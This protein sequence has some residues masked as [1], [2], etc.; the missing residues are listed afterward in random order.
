MNEPGADPDR[1]LEERLGLTSQDLAEKAGRMI[2][3]TF[4]PEEVG[5][6]RQR[7]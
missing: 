4:A 7:S 2:E 5:G 3:A 1:T 6:R